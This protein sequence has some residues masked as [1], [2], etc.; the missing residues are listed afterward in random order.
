MI[1]ER[2]KPFMCQCDRC[3]RFTAKESYVPLR[4]GVLQL[5]QNCS[6]NYAFYERLWMIIEKENKKLILIQ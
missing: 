3:G 1:I 5:C 2:F 4:D 6:Y